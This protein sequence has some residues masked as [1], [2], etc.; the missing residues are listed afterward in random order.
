MEN[1]NFYKVFISFKGTRFLGWQI[2]KDFSP[3]V[4][5]E[6]NKAC[7]LVFKSQNVHTIGS[8]RT[9][10]GVHSLGHVVK[11]EAPFFIE[12]ESLKKALNT[13]LPSDIRVHRVEV[14][15]EGF[16]PTN[17]AKQKTYK[18]LFTNLSEVNPFAGD[19]I[20]NCPYE[21]DFELMQK[22]CVLFIGKHNFKDFQCTGSDVSSTIREIFSCSLYQQKT[23]FHGIIGDHWVVEITGN[24]FLKQ[25]VRLIV[26]SLWNVGRGKTSLDQIEQ[27]LGMPTQ[28]RLG[29]VAPACGLYKVSVDY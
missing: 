5:G 14:C 8:G 28:K 23:S 29:P 10:T 2:Q 19:F 15:D 20:A 22:A 21:L 12:C 7:S 16:L 9:D 25:M 26:G 4:Q 18:Y 13:N 6:F 24:G 11:L 3:T 27:S 17:H 1:N